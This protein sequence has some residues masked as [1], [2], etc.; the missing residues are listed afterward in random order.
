MVKLTTIENEVAGVE[1]CSVCPICEPNV[2]G[3]IFKDK[4]PDGFTPL[5]I[6]KKDRTIT[7]VKNK[8]AG[9]EP[10]HDVLIDSPNVGL[11]FKDKLPDGFDPL[12][13]KGN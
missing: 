2:I 4:L 8:V 3:V 13:V 9:I 1:I 12:F 7:T 5:F 10:F 6:K 11:L